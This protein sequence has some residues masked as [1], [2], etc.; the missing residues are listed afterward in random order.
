MMQLNDYQNYCGVR[1]DRKLN[2]QQM[3]GVATL[4]YSEHYDLKLSELL[5]FFH[6]LKC[7][8]YGVMYGKI[9]PIVIMTGLRSFREYRNSV[10]AEA[11]VEERKRE[12]EEWK[13]TTMTYAQYITKH[14]LSN[15]DD[16][17]A[18]TIGL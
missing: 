17:G 9:D 12:R 6:K 3:E 1:E 10:I 13:K 15:H 7:G 14:K 4:I 16:K 2:A 18:A 11:E 5:L 8:T